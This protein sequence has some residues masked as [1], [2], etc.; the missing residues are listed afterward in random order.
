M[1]EILLIII[2]ISVVII[3]LCMPY[4][5]SLM[6]LAIIG[7]AIVYVAPF[8]LALAISGGYALYSAMPVLPASPAQPAIN[9]LLTSIIGWAAALV[10]SGAL[11]W[12]GALMIRRIIWGRTQ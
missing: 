4:G 3:A 8:V 7:A 9:G 11:I 1:I 12:I 10:Y 6:G 2:A 5:P